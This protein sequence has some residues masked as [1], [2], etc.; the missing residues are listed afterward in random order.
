[1]ID[2][3]GLVDGTEFFYLDYAYIGGEWVAGSRIMAGTPTATYRGNSVNVQDILRY[4]LD[5]GLAEELRRGVLKHSQSRIPVLTASPSFEE[6]RWPLV[7]LHVSQDASQERF[8]GEVLNTDTFNEVE[9]VWDDDEGWLSR[10]Q[11]TII[12]WSKNPDERKA[13]REAIKRVIV[14]NL[15]VFESE[16]MSTVDFNQQDVDDF[17]TY[18]A[19]VYECVCTFSCLARTAVSSPVSPIR[20]VETVI[21]PVRVVPSPTQF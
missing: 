9:D 3:I 8:L 15:A 2:A 1:M 12:G 17:Q 19:P 18:G 10:W 4:R 11:L 20:E 14:A 7:T 21:K 5:V 16:G 6:T 13:L